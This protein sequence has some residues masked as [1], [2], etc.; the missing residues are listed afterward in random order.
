[1]TEGETAPE[2][3]ADQRR[4]VDEL[5][6][7]AAE[8]PGVEVLGVT[9]PHLSTGV[10]TVEVSLATAGAGSGPRGEQQ[11]AQL[12]DRE[13]FRI[14]IDRDYPFRH[15][16]V[17]VT[18][19]RFAD[20]HHVQWRYHLCLYVSP[21]TEWQPSDGMFGLVDRLLFW[22]DRA[23]A[24]ALEAAGERLHP[25]A[26]YSTAAAGAL[27]ARADTPPIPETTELTL[28]VLRRRTP[29]RADIVGWLPL[30]DALTGHGDLSATLERYG[31]A[32]DVDLGLAIMLARPTAFEFPRTVAHLRRMLARHDLTD[33]RLLAGLSLLAMFRARLA[34]TVGLDQAG[35]V[36]LVIATPMRGV[37]GGERHQHLAA[38]R[39]DDLGGQVT[40]ML[41]VAF[42]PYEGVRQLSPQVR[43]LMEN[44]LKIAKLRWVRL[45]DARPQVTVRRDAGG[46]AT[47]VAGRRVLLLGGGALG[48]QIAAHLV[49]GGAAELRL[50]D[51]GKVSPGVL[52]RQ[53]FIDAD[54]DE[55]K[56]DAL[57]RRLDAIETSTVIHTMT[58]DAMTLFSDDA[59][60]P[61][62]DL[63][64]DATANM[65]L[66][67]RIERHRR[68]HDHYPPLMTLLA[69]FQAT[70][71][72]A[73]VAPSDYTGAGVDL[74]R[75]TKIIT[76]SAPKLTA[77]A[78]DFFPDPPRT[79]YFQPEPGCSEATFTGSNA[80]LAAL[81][82]TLLLHALRH[83][84]EPHASVTLCDLGLD[85]NP[86]LETLP[87]RRDAIAADTTGYE[88][89]I[90]PTV[91]T[92]W[93]AETRLMARRRDPSVETGGVL[94][95]EID[96]ACG[97]IWISAVTGPPP[98]SHASPT[99]FVCGVEGVDNLVSHHDRRSRG[100]VRFLG[101]WH[102]HPFG[103]AQPSPTDRRGMEDLLVPVARAPR[104]AVLAI[105]GG[106]DDWAAW[107]DT[108]SESLPDIFLQ[109]CSRTDSAII[110]STPGTDL[111][112]A[113]AR[114]GTGELR[115]WPPPKQDLAVRPSR[116]WWWPW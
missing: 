64:I 49:R 65:A 116:H 83:S 102:T 106:S 35:S 47:A 84:N 46:P 74:L 93:R 105:L 58:D 20:L 103:P 13:R 56:A 97:V 82:G 30:P 80:Q 66:T 37:A 1:M 59:A 85:S 61:D 53:D 23:A 48:G 28:V 68:A 39:F 76:S 57:A 112:A 78:D 25:P 77:F 21:G 71:G 45:Y 16:S 98:D 38:W 9:G 42:S 95:G 33:D 72:M 36:Y 51:N 2:P 111:P 11:L 15:P 4:A 26:V 88:M 43:S 75:K 69:G 54:I 100:A 24:G 8:G 89:R 99:A 18:H 67:A 60:P 62:A 104:R 55:F 94:L 12:R 34:E 86:H 22:L 70:R 115:R 40:D 107:R 7:I 29:D 81:A 5:R 91:V 108:N 19:D 27:I 17:W 31:A 79:E 92:E 87:V 90:A 3:T 41:D 114:A 63:I 32:K 44:W 96:D 6:A 73:L 109:V 10:L 101:L 52:V 50:V 110:P 113:L 14:L